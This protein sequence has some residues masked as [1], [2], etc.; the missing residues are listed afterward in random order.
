MISLKVVDFLAFILLGIIRASRIYSFIYVI[1]F[2]TCSAIIITSNIS[3][4]PF[5]FLSFG[6]PILLMLHLLKQSHSSRVFC[7]IFFSI[8]FLLPLHFNLG[9]FY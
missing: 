6:I 5:S 4:T 1:R 8:L 3:S 9:R 2:K 7:S